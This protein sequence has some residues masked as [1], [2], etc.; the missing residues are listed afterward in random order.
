MERKSKEWWTLAV[1][2][3]ARLRSL[4]SS[5]ESMTSLLGGRVVSRM[6]RPRQ[7]TWRVEDAGYVNHDGLGIVKQTTVRQLKAGY[8]RRQRGVGMKLLSSKMAAEDEMAARKREM[9]LRGG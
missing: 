9:R 8:E 5:A 7:G 2:T 4:A 3:T 1:A 6:H